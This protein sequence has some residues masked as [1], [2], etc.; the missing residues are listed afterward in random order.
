MK[1]RLFLIATLVLF[2]GSAVAQT[3]TAVERE[4]VGYLDNIS[5][6]GSYGGGYDGE[7]LSRNNGDLRDKLL[8][9]GKRADI[10]KFA[11]PGLKDKMYVTTSKDRRFRIYSWDLESGGTMH[12]FDSV[13]Q[14]EGKS[15]KIHTWTEGNNDGESVGAFY[16]QIFQTDI[17][18]GPI[19]LGVSTFIGSTSYAGQTIKAFRINGEK[20]DTDAKVI[21]TTSGVK[22]SIS[23]AYDFFSVVDHPERPVRLVFY[24]ESNK[25]FR[26]PVVIEDKRTPQG[27]VTSKFI[28]YRF[29]GKYFVKV[30]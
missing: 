16:H 9:Y 21:R 6:Y 27:R 3:P 17:A 24:N 29:D 5:T 1:I 18:S 11:F 8:K 14:Y 2:S 12:E 19:Y 26:F 10:L 30:G 7:K 28:T 22:S 25:S 15:G 4:F 20:L 13:F 23:F